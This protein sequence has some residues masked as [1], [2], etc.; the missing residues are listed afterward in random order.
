ML[1][2]FSQRSDGPFPAHEPLV[3]RANFGNSNA[4]FPLTPALSPRERENRSPLLRQSARPLCSESGSTCLPLH[5]GEG[6]GE[7]ER[8]VCRHDG[9]TNLRFRGAR[10]AKTS[11]NSLLEGRVRVRAIVISSDRSLNDCFDVLHP[12]HLHRQRQHFHSLFLRRR[13]NLRVRVAHR[14]PSQTQPCQVV[15]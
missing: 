8:D 10:R 3:E 2:D 15:L 14:N 4:S 6:R 11:G 12:R 5:K 7:G 1:S 9:F 13:E